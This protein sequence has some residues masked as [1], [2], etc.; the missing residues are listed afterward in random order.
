MPKLPDYLLAF[1][2]VTQIRRSRGLR[3]IPPTVHY[4]STHSGM[5]Y[6]T[7]LSA[8]SAGTTISVL[9]YSSTLPTR[10]LAQTHQ[11]LHI[12]MYGSLPDA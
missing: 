10:Y 7:C 8:D 9:Q 6:N 11:A 5:E 3:L 2:S 1:K 12:T 4:S